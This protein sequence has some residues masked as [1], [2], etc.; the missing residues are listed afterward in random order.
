MHADAN[1]VLILYLKFLARVNNLNVQDAYSVKRLIP[2]PP[3]RET[4]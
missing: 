1:K 3:F 4:Q 2:V